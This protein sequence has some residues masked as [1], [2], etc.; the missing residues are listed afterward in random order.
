LSRNQ[1]FLASTQ[2]EKCFLLFQLRSFLPKFI[3]FLPK[4]IK[5]FT[6]IDLIFTQIDEISNFWRQGLKSVTVHVEVCQPEMTKNTK[7]ITKIEFPLAYIIT[8]AVTSL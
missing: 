3:K 8:V 5:F 4:F 7:L 1:G 6:Q 2:N